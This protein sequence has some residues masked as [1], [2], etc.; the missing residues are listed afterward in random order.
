MALQD[1]CRNAENEK[2]KKP[3]SRQVKKEDGND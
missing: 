3:L 1:G 2:R